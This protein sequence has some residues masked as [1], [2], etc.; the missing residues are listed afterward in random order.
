MIYVTKSFLPAPE[1]YLE[2]I[3]AIFASGVLTNNGA[4]VR[5]LHDDL[6]TF[7][8]VE[9]LSVLSNGTLAIQLPLRLIREDNRREVITTPFSYVA[10]TNSLLWEDFTPVY[11]D[12]D[13][14]TCCIDA[15]LIEASITPATCAILATHVYGIPC[16]VEL[17]E[18]IA[19]KHNLT[20]IYDAAHAFGVKY[21]GK[22]VL[23][24]GDFSTLSFHATKLFHSVEGGAVIC[25]SQ[26][27]LS[28]VDLLR[29]FGHIRDDYFSIGINAKM[30][31]L[32]AA[33]GLC[34]LP[35]VHKLKQ[36]REERFTAYDDALRGIE[37]FYPRVSEGTE[38]NF[39]YYPVIFS[40]GE[41]RAR[42]QDAL[43]KEDIF[44]RRYF[45]P[46]LNVLPHHRG[47]SCPVSED[48]AERVL[49]LPM[50]HDLEFSDIERIATII[51][52]AV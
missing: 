23:R 25:N 26:E 33:M 47:E 40:D 52:K 13:P 28:Q 1:E 21:K 39:S 20:V 29:S 46:S 27:H 19:R 18:S 49:C 32:H 42:V 16:D 41:V 15:K 34:V 11:V 10:T 17:I 24:Y 44:P 7:L 43:N 3:N 22:S 9:F 6:V 50:Y 5:Q 2:K 48:Y 8:D 35:H 12:I 36:L 51:R 30:S 14:A 4:M 38:Y 37:L 31:E 45:Y